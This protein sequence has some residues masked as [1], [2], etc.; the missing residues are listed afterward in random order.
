VTISG[1]HCLRFHFAA[2]TTPP[3]ILQE[4]DANLFVAQAIKI[5]L[6]SS[7]ARSGVSALAFHTT[8]TESG[9]PDASA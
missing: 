9:A 2:Q 5:L 1:L 6:A 8:N 3:A 4:P 7:E